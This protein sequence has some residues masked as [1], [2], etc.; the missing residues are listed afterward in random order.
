MRRKRAMSR[1]GVRV[2][3]LANFCP[4]KLGT[5]ENR[6][7]AL[8]HAVRKRGHAI[9]FF[10]HD[11]VHPTVAEE[12]A[13]AGATW[14]RLNDLAARPFASARRLA[15]EFDVIQLNALAPRSRAAAVA[16]AAWPTPVLFVDHVSGPPG[17]GGRPVR[18]SL[19][20]RG[21]DQITMMRVRHFAGVSDYVRRR[22][23]HRFSLPADRTLTVYGGV[24]TI[25]FHPPA[26]R[27]SS[28]EKTVRIAC[29]A[30]LI[31]EKGVGTLLRAVS[32]IPPGGWK[33]RIVGAGPEAGTLERSAEALGLAERVEFLGL[34]DDVDE[35]L[36]DSHVLV[37]PAVWEE[38]LGYTVLEGMASGCAVI[39]S[40]VGGIPELIE[41]GVEGILVEPANVDHLTKALADLLGDAQDRERLGDAARRR[42]VQD[43]SLERNVRLTLDWFEAAAGGRSLHE[44]QTSLRI[45]EAE[46]LE[47]GDNQ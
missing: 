14:E 5:G 28:L 4:R 1:G 39:A 3:Y 47:K 27:P 18:R 10:G 8:A 30:A 20:R 41:H 26:S 34:R 31:P 33:L 43:F 25:R 16:Y 32:R 23:E 24:D 38:A 11:P 12:W 37:H 46:Q 6:L 7:V 2:A 44:L 13:A 29:V 35:I 17:S 21:L 9:T 36:R 40:R 45:A 42:V 15:R 19:L 22:G